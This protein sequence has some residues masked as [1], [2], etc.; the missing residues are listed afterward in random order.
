VLKQ[1]PFRRLR[2][3]LKGLPLIPGVILLLFIVVGFLG[4]YL[5]PHDPNE[6][7]FE[8]ALTPPFWQAGGKIST[9]LGTDELGRDL[10]SRLIG[11]LGIPEQI[12]ADRR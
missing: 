11:E 10:L 4:V 3:A 1:R 2:Q 5:M 7:R 12:S 9:P 8:N 6:A